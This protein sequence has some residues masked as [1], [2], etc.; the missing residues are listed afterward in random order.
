ML[1]IDTTWKVK[2]IIEFRDEIVKELGNTNV[3]VV[4][5]GCKSILDA[6]KEAD[7]N[8]I[9]GKDTTPFLLDKVQ[10]LTQGKSLEA[11]VRLVFN[12]VKLASKIAIEYSKLA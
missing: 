2:E 4:C 7:E 1:H 6:L 3:A 10:K 5:A 9:K 8:G 11:N 12:N